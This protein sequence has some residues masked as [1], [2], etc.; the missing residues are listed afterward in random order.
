MLVPIYQPTVP[1][2]RTPEFSRAQALEFKWLFIT[3]NKMF[4]LFPVSVPH[5][6]FPSK[7]FRTLPRP[8]KKNVCVLEYLLNELLH[9]KHTYTYSISSSQWRVL[10]VSSI[11]SVRQRMAWKIAANNSDRESDRSL[12][13]TSSLFC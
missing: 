9:I 6:A 1:H 10:N 5:H 7:V 3:S 4:M 8:R 12:L 11:N 13:G 2:P